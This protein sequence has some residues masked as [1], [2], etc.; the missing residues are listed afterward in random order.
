[1]GIKSNIVA[2]LNENQ[3][4]LFKTKE[5]A[6]HFKIPEAGYQ[7]FKTVIKELVTDGKIYKYK[8]GKVGAGRRNVTLVGRIDIKSQG[9]GFLLVEGQ[10]EDVYISED[11]MGTAF[12]G[13]LVRVE[14]FQRGKGKKKEGRVVEVIERARVNIVGVYF[15]GKSRGTIVPD[16]LEIHRDII[17]PHDKSHDAKPGQKVVAKLASWKDA[18]RNP[19]AEIIEILGYPD[20][21]GVDVLSIAK[22]HNI[23]TD[24]PANV[25]AELDRMDIT[26]DRDEI[27][28]RLD[29]R[30]EMI[31]TIDP[32][33]AKDFDDAISLT[34]L[35]N[36]NYK[37]GV[38]IA[39]VSYFVRAKSALDRVARERGTSIYLVDRVIPMLPERLSNDLCSLRPNEDHLCFS[40]IMEMNSDGE[41]LSYQIV[42]SI[43]NSKRRFTYEQ[44]QTLIETPDESDP[45]NS[46]IQMMLVLNKALLT[47]RE[48][49]GGLDF[50][51]NEVKIKL[52]ERGKPIGV[53]RYIQ[54]DS[55]RIIEE[56]MILANRIVAAHVSNMND[57]K[58][59]KE[60]PYVYRVHEKP[61][62][63]KLEEFRKFLLALNV[64]FVLRKKV[65]PKMFQRLIDQVRGTEKEIIVG[66]VMT[67]SMMKAKYDVKNVGHFG[68]AL[69][70]Y[71]HFTSPIRRYPDLIGHRILKS[72]LAKQPKLT[73]DKTELSKICE[74]ATSR[75]IAAQEAERE[76]VRLKK[77]EFMEDH[78][79]DEFKGIISG[80]ASYGIFVEIIETLAEGLVHIS[81]LPGDY[82]VHDK[83]RYR[84]YGERT[85]RAFQLGD[86]VHVKVIRVNTQDKLI[87]LE[88]ADTADDVEPQY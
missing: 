51:S 14:L 43:I 71:S 5:L 55:H 44:V 13:D 18:R 52:D 39:D 37:L 8:K 84:L 12:D 77:V 57:D 34:R 56:F 66:D 62:V 3:G 75:E 60:Y 22:S 9:Y 28:R 41:V 32:E 82:Y 46:V 69:K 78:I 6:R 85:H 4:K 10:A 23:Q 45:L 19:E 79:G 86:V 74:L 7:D 58:S 2:F 68:L 70:Y 1:M 20:D 42:E 88:L 27:V 47:R 61:S 15:T 67:R 76:S 87:D 64:D 17:V 26:I 80:V 29:L 53:E 36:G 48:A 40:V 38:H 54:K 65:N 25:Q 73:I 63:E 49:R 83:D 16:D 21:P 72:Y 24:F 35:D 11:N 59:G 50:G 30:D 33:D 31:F 81:T